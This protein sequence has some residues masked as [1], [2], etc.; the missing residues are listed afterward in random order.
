MSLVNKFSWSGHAPTFI[1]PQ[2]RP[3]NVEF[4]SFFPSSP[5]H[6][7]R[8]K[9]D[10]QKGEKPLVQLAPS[11]CFY[12][13]SIIFL[14]L[15]PFHTGRVIYDLAFFLALCLDCP[16]WIACLLAP[17]FI[18]SLSRFNKD[19]SVL[20]S[21]NSVCLPKDHSPFPRETVSCRRLWCPLQRLHSNLV[22][23]LL[24]LGRK[25]KS[26]SPHEGTLPETNKILV[27]CSSA[28]PALDI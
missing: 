17:R 13:L 28:V 5:F 12:C 20:L 23:I 15:H 16:L 27:P 24:Q 8:E 19:S 6:T 14:L 7:V 11:T 18:K 26:R 22:C 3:K 1:R 4:F 9:W 2:F 21:I 25:V 10:K